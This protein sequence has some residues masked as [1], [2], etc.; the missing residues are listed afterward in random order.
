MLNTN[1]ENDETF[2]EK[3][4]YMIFKA[5]ISNSGELLRLESANGK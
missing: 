3:E 5:V 4:I 2:T 1:K